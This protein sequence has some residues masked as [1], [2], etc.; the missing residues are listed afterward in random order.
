MFHLDSTSRLVL[1]RKSRK[2]LDVTS[3]CG[4]IKRFSLPGSECRRDQARSVHGTKPFFEAVTRQ[5]FSEPFG[6]DTSKMRSWKAPRDSRNIHDL[7]WASSN[8]RA[9][10]VN[11]QTAQR[12]H[13]TKE[14]ATF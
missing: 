10:W 12:L 8:G 3:V 4:F 13:R 5:H 14:S 1:V 7:E 11:D 2:Q 6:P 9:I